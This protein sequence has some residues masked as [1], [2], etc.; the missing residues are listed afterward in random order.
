MRPKQL[1]WPVDDFTRTPYRVYVDENLF[2]LEQERIFRGPNWHLIGLESEVPNYGDF[3]TTYVGNTPIVLSRNTDNML[4][5]F[6]NRCAHRGARVVRERRGNN[7]RHTCIYHRWCY[8]VA[9]KLIGVPLQKGYAGE[10]GYSDDFKKSDHHLTKLRCE[11]YSGVV[12]ASFDD[13]A[14]DLIDY[15]G[16]AAAER[17]SL[18]CHKPLKVLG[19]IHQTLSANWKLFVENNRD[20]YHGPL[21]H[22]FIPAFDLL[23]L[24]QKSSVEVY[25]EGH[26]L[27]TSHRIAQD[28]K[29]GNGEQSAAK[30]G[31]YRLEDERVVTGFP[32]FGGISL[33][34][35]S[36]FPAGLFTCVGNLLTCRQI[37]PKSIDRTEV[38]YTMFAYE[39]DDAEILEARKIQGN[40]EGPSGYAAMEDIEVLE[41]VQSSLSSTDKSSCSLLEFGGNSIKSEPHMN[42]EASIRCFW[43]TYCKAMNIQYFKV[44]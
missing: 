26:A 8:D 13:D 28:A 25:H 29:V 5:A 6:V 39:D 43:K 35:L 32:E 11:S 9:G 22:H 30:A 19:H 41:L 20:A 27:I 18:I 33:T 12:F 10:G 44:N 31:K 21:L 2:E 4:C 40:I 15:L 1:V 7:K 24:D 37:R 23:Q 17:I 14:P 36:L 3:T 16:I 38:K 34:V 42:S